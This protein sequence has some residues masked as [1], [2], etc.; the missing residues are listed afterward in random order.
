MTVLE[1]KEVL[2]TKLKELN[3]DL[4]IKSPKFIR[5]QE[6][7]TEYKTILKNDKSLRDYQLHDKKVLGITILKEE[8]DLKNDDILIFTKFWDW[9]TKEV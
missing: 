5:L 1:L 9:K 6:R 2:V 3:N 8:E 7:Y 4:E